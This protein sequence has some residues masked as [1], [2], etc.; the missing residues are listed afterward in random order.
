MEIKGYCDTCDY[1]EETN[2][3]YEFQCHRFPPGILSGSHFH[4]ET[5][6]PR[7]DKTDYCAEYKP[8]K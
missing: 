4:M 1:T 8:K 3:I 7:V 2:T 5:R 6:F